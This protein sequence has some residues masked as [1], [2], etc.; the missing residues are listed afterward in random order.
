MFK[1]S[2]LIEDQRMAADCPIKLED[3]EFCSRSFPPCSPSFNECKP[4]RRQNRVVVMSISSQ[5]RWGR[6]GYSGR[7]GN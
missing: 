4:A 2:S 7:Y 5:Y 3:I 6:L 1:G